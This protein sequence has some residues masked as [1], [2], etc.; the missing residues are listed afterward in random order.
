[1][2][3]KDYKNKNSIARP[4]ESDSYFRGSVRMKVV[5]VALLTLTSLVFTQL[6][7]ANSL[8]TDGDKLSKVQQEIKN[9]EKENMAIKAEI[10][11]Y[12]SLSN[13][14]KKAKEQGFVKPQTVE[15]AN[16]H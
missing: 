4:V 11:K 10:A 14:S 12:S 16:K 1:M 3:H 13:L 6:I 5:A 8:A 15:V 7:F 9:L 2:L